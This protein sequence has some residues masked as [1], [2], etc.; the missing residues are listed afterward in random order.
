MGRRVRAPRGPPTLFEED[1]IAEN[2][3]EDGRPVPY[4]EPGARLLVTNLANRVQP[5]VRLEVP[6]AVTLAREPCACG[7]TL[8]VM[9]RIDGRADDVIRLPGAN[10]DPVVIHPLQFSVVARDRD[11]IEFQVVQEGTRLVVH[12]VGRAEGVEDRVRANLQERLA[13]LGVRDATIDVRRREA[14]ERS[15]GGKLQI[16]MADRHA[17]SAT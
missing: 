7:R 6:D 13:A 10:G 5:I 14:L 1:V 9:R 3:D 4:G 8:R 11:V 15:A 17:L 2:V 16:V 12:L